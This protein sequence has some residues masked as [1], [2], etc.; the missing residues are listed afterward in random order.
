MML[1]ADKSGL[2]EMYNADVIVR[3][4]DDIVNKKG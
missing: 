2:A 1:K 4:M 3:I